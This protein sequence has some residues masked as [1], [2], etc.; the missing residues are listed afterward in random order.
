VLKSSDGGHT[1][2]RENSGLT[3]LNAKGIAVSPH[4]PATLLLGTSGNSVF[5][6]H[7]A[8]ARKVK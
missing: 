1:W 5:L 8:A 2:R 3:L 7:D 6:G 4:D